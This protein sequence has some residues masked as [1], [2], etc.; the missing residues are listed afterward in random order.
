V[1]S[2]T[3][4]S[5]ARRTNRKGKA[6]RRLKPGSARV[7]LQA[8]REVPTSPYRAAEERGAIVSWMLQASKE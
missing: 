5:C 3:A 7:A 2:N 8:V 6:A 1:P 4:E